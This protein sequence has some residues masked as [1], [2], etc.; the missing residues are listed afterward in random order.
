MA[1]FTAVFDI[2]CAM[3]KVQINQRGLKLDGTHHLLVCVADMCILC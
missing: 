3:G 2:Q 1:T